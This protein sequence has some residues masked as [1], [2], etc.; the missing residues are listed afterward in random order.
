[1]QKK[2]ADAIEDVY[3]DADPSTAQFDMRSCE[4]QN[5]VR[6]VRHGTTFEVV[7]RVYHMIAQGLCPVARWYL[8]RRQYL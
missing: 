3:D 4:L 1:M 5:C 6:I 7:L 8:Y 2:I